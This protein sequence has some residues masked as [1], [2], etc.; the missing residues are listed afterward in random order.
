MHNPSRD[1]TNE[2]YAAMSGETEDLRKSLSHFLFFLHQVLN[3]ERTSGIIN[4][5]LRI[6][7]ENED[8]LE[9]IRTVMKESSNMVE[10]V[11][12]DEAEAI[13]KGR[14]NR[15]GRMLGK[16]RLLLDKYKV[17]QTA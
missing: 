1:F 2:L 6:A 17:K 10:L 11:Y 16:L 7:Q 3:D 13:I 15:W 4:Q 5:I 12:Q 8:M 9:D 14:K